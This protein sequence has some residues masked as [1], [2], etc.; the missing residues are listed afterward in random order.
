MF[1][2]DKEVS[3]TVP[4]YTLVIMDTSYPNILKKKT[5]GSFIT[6]QGRERESNFATDV[7]RYN[8]LN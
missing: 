7:G 6:P 8:L 4:R 2:Y 5:C 3:L 1:C